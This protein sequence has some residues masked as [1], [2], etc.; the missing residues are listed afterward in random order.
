MTPDQAER[1]LGLE[2]GHS[3]QDREEALRQKS[4]DLES[5]I[6]RAPTQ[7][8]KEK[9]RRSLDQIEEASAVL[10]KGAEGSEQT[11]NFPTLRPVVADKVFS[12]SPPIIARP[13]IHKEL[14]PKARPLL[15]W[16][17][18]FLCL[19][20]VGVDILRLLVLFHFVT[21]G[22]RIQSHEQ[23]TLDTAIQT[24]KSIAI[25]PT[26]GIG[27]VLLLFLRRSAFYFFAV[28]FGFI[29]VSF[30]FDMFT[31]GPSLS[32]MVGILISSGMNIA[33]L[34]YLRSLIRNG[35]LR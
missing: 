3:P 32:L 1:L 8:L 26:W 25:V 34:L 14:A 19:D 2:E 13:E 21:I 5:K 24:A 18:S 15:V 28:G 6:E 31:E 23:S 35:V 10:L 29:L 11:A 12:P 7:G 16:V 22:T 27:A 9:Y 17:I 20:A 4:H 30:I 33:M